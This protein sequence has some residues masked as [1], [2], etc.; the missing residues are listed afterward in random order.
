M[1]IHDVL[2][3][4]DRENAPD[5]FI[6]MLGDGAEFGMS[7]T[8]RVQQGAGGIA[9]ALLLA[10]PFVNN[11]QCYV[12]LGDNIF[13]QNEFID[14]QDP[15]W[16][17]ELGIDHG[18][19]IFVKQVTNPK[20]YGVIGSM[21]GSKVTSIIEKPSEPP[22][23]LAVVGL[24]IYPASVFNIIPT[25]QP[26]RRGE[27]EITDVNN[28]FANQQLLISRSVQGFWGDAGGSIDLFLRVNEHMIRSQI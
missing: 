23:N 6:A 17:Q 14:W 19:C 3:V 4:L 10:K 21:S 20:D 9:A 25:L 1:G 15:D 8:Y 24:Y 5:R 16:Q 22:T 2:V 26:S 27:L 11:R 12:I 13:D 18:A 7:I 28:Y